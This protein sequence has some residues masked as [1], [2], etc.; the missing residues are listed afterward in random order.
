MNALP[1]TRDA[2]GES[3]DSTGRRARRIARH[4]RHA[5]LDIGSELRSLMSE[6]EEA[7]GDGTH[8]DAAA[9][10]AQLRKRLD[11]ARARLDDTRAAV[12]ERAEIALADAD[13]YVRENPWKTIAVVGGIALVAGALL[14]H[15]SH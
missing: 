2:I 15:S 10:R 13:G 5:A 12:R 8:A 11:A 6:L 4:G 1:N 9:L 7:L 3:L 14:A